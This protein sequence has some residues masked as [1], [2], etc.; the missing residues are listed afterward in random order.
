MSWTER[1]R[2]RGHDYL[3]EREWAL[4]PET[5]HRYKRTVRYL[6]RCDRKGRL[7]ERPQTRLGPPHSAFPAGSL[8]VLYATARD[9]RLRERIQQVLELEALPAAHLLTLTLNPEPRTV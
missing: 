7:V 9:L 8:A 3:Y 4:A 5:G 2:I 1:V 6:G